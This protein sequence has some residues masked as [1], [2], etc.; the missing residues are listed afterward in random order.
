M[1][2]TERFIR[3]RDE[4]RSACL[5]GAE[6]GHPGVQCR[7]L[8]SPTRVVATTTKAVVDL[9]GGLCL[10]RLIVFER[11]KEEWRREQA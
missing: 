5:I 2:A 1:R 7:D 10:A 3:T 11:H 4:E 6:R 9:H 8:E